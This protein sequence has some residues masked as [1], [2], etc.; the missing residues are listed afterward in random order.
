MILKYH[1][2]ATEDIYKILY[3]T[4][5]SRINKADCVK[6]QICSN[7]FK[8]YFSRHFNMTLTQTSIKVFSSND[9]NKSHNLESSMPVWWLPVFINDD[10]I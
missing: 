7:Y 9:S 2:S 8:H 1:N 4:T 6:F 3:N 5:L 10:K